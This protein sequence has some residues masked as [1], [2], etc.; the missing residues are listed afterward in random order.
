MTKL[1]L[2]HG[3][4]GASARFQP[5]LQLLG[6]RDA[7]RLSALIPKLPGFEGRPLPEGAISWAPFIEALQRSVEAAGK[8]GEWVLYGHGIGGSLL[9]EWASRGWALADGGCLKPHKVILHGCIGASL[10]HRFFPKLMQPMAVR[11]LMQWLIAWPA[12][13]P[14]WERRLFLHP[15]RIPSGLRQQFFRDYKTCAAFSLFFDLIT[16]A[17]YQT[18][19]EQLQ[20][21]KFC[22]I[23]GDKERVVASRF[24]KYW[25]QDFP[26]S[27]FDIVP[28]WDHFPMLDQPKAFYD[29]VI[30]LCNM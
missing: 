10:E 7:E 9:L 25:Q 16:P 1:L 5:F 24:L 27:T 28:G 13:Q 2:L 17:W 18:V 8:D 11:R 3:N 20:A 29:K 4:G 30:G 22:F 26:H 19:Q 21:E 12:L 23:W 15:E 6:E 14:I